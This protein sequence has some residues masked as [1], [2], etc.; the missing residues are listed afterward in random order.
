M[1]NF[2]FVAEYKEYIFGILT[3]I[4]MF[5]TG[6]KTKKT[7]EN[8]G[9]LQN[10]SVELANLSVI[11]EMEKQLVLDAKTQA[12]ELREII[13]SLQLIIDQKDK[14]IFEQQ[15]ICEAQKTSLI[16]QKDLIQKQH[17]QLESFRKKLDSFKNTK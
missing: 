11:R 15:K 6:R 9:V 2:S 10:V 5:F 17:R 13:A 8:K 3:S 4:A 16:E 12:G 14:I 1:E 7:E